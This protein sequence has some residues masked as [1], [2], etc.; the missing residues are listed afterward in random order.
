M[1][2]MKSM[3][4]QKKYLGFIS[5]ICCFV[6][7]ILFLSGCQPLK[8]KFTRKKKKGKVL[9]EFIPVLEPIDYGP[10]TI[11]SKDRYSKHFSLWRIWEKDFVQNVSS[12]TNDKRMKYLLNQMV[13]HLNEMRKWIVEEKRNELDQLISEIIKIKKEFNK[14]AQSRNTNA[15]KRRVES[16]ARKILR[17]FKPG[18]VDEYFIQ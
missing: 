8:R 17:D 5:F 9:Q 10:S 6:I 14:P 18:T 4:M 12:E 16:N 13:E 15:I 1:F 3:N 7:L 11:T 2:N